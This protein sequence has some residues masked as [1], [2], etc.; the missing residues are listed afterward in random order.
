MTTTS[1]PDLSN[2]TLRGGDDQFHDYDHFQ[3]SP[4]I[5][6]G[7][8]N[9]NPFQVQQQ[10]KTPS[11]AGLPNVSRFLPCAEPTPTLT[12]ASSNGSTTP[13]RDPSRHP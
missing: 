10:P 4:P 11:R 9:Y 8:S 6:P 1:T 5:I 13:R 3:T 12:V 2:L 7:Q